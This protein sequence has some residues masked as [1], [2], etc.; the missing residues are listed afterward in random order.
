[1]DVLRQDIVIDLG[2]PDFTAGFLDAEF[3]EITIGKADKARTEDIA[4]DDLD[5]RSAEFG[6]VCISDR[7]GRLGRDLDASG[8]ALAAGA[9]AGAAGK[10]G[11]GCQQANPFK[12]GGMG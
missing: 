7:A 1:M 8:L 11:G 10:H 5:R 12:T 4:G 6:I 2:R 9:H 3:A